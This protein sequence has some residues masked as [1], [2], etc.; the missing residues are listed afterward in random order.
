MKN[1]KVKNYAAFIIFSLLINLY[2]TDMGYCLDP[3]LESS[4][5]Y[6]SVEGIVNGYFETTG[7]G[8]SSDVIEHKLESGGQTI[9]KKIPGRLSYN[10]VTLKRKITSNTDM[11]S[12]RKQ[13]EDGF[14]DLAKKDSTVVI[15]DDIGSEVMRGQLIASW[16]SSIQLV[17]ED[18]IY[19]EEIT[20]VYDKFVNESDMIINISTYITD[21]TAYGV[22]D[23]SIT[24]TASGGGGTYEYS[25]DNGANWQDSNIFSG[26]SAGS[27]EIMARDKADT[28]NA[29][30]AS[31]VT[32]SE[33]NAAVTISV[34]NTDATSYGVSDG[35]ITVTA[36]GG[37]GTYEY[38]IDNGA[39][40]QDS[41]IFSGLS[42]GS[43]EVKARDKA[44]TGNLSAASSVTISEPNATVTISVSNTDAT[45][46]GISDGSITVTA[47][48]G[49]GTYEYSID[50][51]ANWQD[52]NIFSG[53]S[54]GSY[55]VKAR[56]KADT[57]NLSAASSVTISEPNATVT[58][59]VSNTD[60]TSYGVSDGSITVTASGGGGTYEYSIDNGAN[61]QDS[62]IFSGLSAGSYEV[63]ARDKADTGN[64]SA[65]SSVTISE[66]NATVTISVSNTDATSYGV[67]DGSITVT[68]SGGGGTYEYSIDNG[69]NWQDSNIF[70]GLSAGSYEIMARDKADTG[71][72][73]VA[74]SVTIS[75]P[76]SAVTISVSKTDATAYG[77]SDGSI[78]VTASGGGGTYEYSIDNGA[79]WQDSNIF[80]GLS[81]GSYEV[82][83]RD[84]AD[85]GNLSAVRSVTISE[86][87]S[88]V[89][90]SVSKTDATAY[91]VSD[92][93]ITVTASGGGG[94]YEYSIDNGANWQDSN[95][96]S[97]LSAGS[98]EVKARDKADTGNLSVA[99]SVTISEPDAAVTISVSNTDATAYGVSDGS[100]TVT[101]SGGGGTYEYSIDNGA[102]WQDSNVF[103]GL[104]AGSYEVKARDKADTG[105]LSAASSVTISEPDATV[106]ISVSNT[107]ATIHGA[108]D[109]SI[110]V[111][112]SGGGGTY[113][114]SI[115]NGA[116][117][118]D[119]NI[120]S[121]L[122]A[123]SYEIMARDKA[124]T[125]NVSAVRSVTISEPGA[126]VTISVTKTDATAYG[127]SD[128]SIMV[129]ASG[130]GGTYEYSIDNGA[131]WQ[132][133]NIFSGLSAGSYEIMARDKADT[134]NVSAVRSV[135]ISEP[136]SAVTI[137]VSKT[138]ATAYG[139]SDGSITVT[140]SGGGG[141]YEYS[142][143]NG[144]NWQDSNVFSGLSAGSYEVKARDK[145]DTGNL[146]AASSVTI[147]EPGAAVTIS[148][149]KT[150]ATAYGAS[151]GSITV[152]ASGGGGTYEYSIDN[153]ANW[154]DSN[155]FSGLSAGS[156]E[157]KARDKA[158][159]GNLS[160]ASSVTI[161]EPNSASSSTRGKNK[162]KQNDVAQAMAEGEKNEE[163]QLIGT[164]EARKT[165]NQGE[166]EQEIPSDYFKADKKALKIETPVA[167]VTLPDNMFAKTPEAEVNLSVTEV[168]KDRLPQS[169]REKFSDKPVIDIDLTIGGQK[170]EWSNDDVEVAITIPYTPTV[171]ELKDPDKIIAVYID[172]DGNTIPVRISS[173]DPESGGVVFKTKHF[174]YY[175]IQYQDKNFG[176]IGRYAWAEESIEALSARGIINGITEKAFAP[177][178]D[179]TRADFVVLLTRLF[180]LEEEG[181]ECDFS[182]VST[183]AYYYRAV[184]AAK[185]RGIILGT[186]DNQFSPA[187]P[188]SRQDM[189][190][191]T[192]RA[193][194]QLK[195][196]SIEED[197]SVL[198]QYRDKEGISGYAMRSLAVLVKEGLITGAGDTIN[199]DTDTT[200][201]EA[202]VFLYRIYNWF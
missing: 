61:W 82:K 54:A 92:G 173:Y 181:T 16:P 23:G 66:P 192:T 84:K 11:W 4:N 147:S 46:Y 123:G 116:N 73:S 195:G 42:A 158:D 20:L 126:A 98:Y 13:V 12:W 128:G 138:D 125:G 49:G 76:N 124:D 166:Y 170:T 45:A 47:S 85:T 156:Y 77:V 189:M 67:S 32:I 62:N 140:A 201:A 35:S 106:T 131:N 60:A 105:N 139:V 141:T 36:S 6:I 55:E 129:T 1:I 175:G 78:T 95:I 26:L 102:N 89:T 29:S 27:Y 88:A 188:I 114:Y 121:G 130:G 53:L 108:S 10:T 30:A 169:I 75:E 178:A 198:N 37:G 172:D 135:T 109:G 132:D 51:G 71:N 118:Q 176:D 22:S 48:G 86:P 163:G 185:E 115:D 144:A 157:V 160:A 196:L 190:V 187:E 194:E 183:E 149:T 65:A 43:Y 17:L 24:V 70:S 9:I 107:D 68:A 145:A 103:S 161:S 119:S 151:D 81:A 142:I 179:L 133:S 117:W 2:P 64:L 137:S 63:K 44:D 5:C 74:S 134:G 154:Q 155:V 122:S 110:T 162:P 19:K 165:N 90:I 127:V 97:G 136:N 72:A 56:D 199:P 182:D 91:G 25:I 31:S 94:T 104:S 167:T 41:N 15:Y 200:R 99:S 87:N 112:A 171:E 180:E 58:I 96:F 111:T 18:G 3:D 150:D 143:D 186:A 164:V 191:I 8:S 152:T 184:C 38:S 59:S 177:E 34:S 33:P 146:S 28:G 148:V 80:S 93:S 52:S 39:N 153:G 57:G 159:T 83:A 202:A 168:S 14:I 40:W 174:S 197:D 50:N 79:N 113:E 7:I 21:A 101:A 69:A 193:L 100:I 120:F